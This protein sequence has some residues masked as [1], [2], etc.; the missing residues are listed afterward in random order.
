MQR[1]RVVSAEIDPVKAARARENLVAAGLENIVELRIGDARETLKSLDAPIDFLLIDSWIPLARPIVEMLKS[2]LRPGAL[3]L[4]DNTG[5]FRTEYRDFL[6][7]VRDPSN[8]FLTIHLP[9][10]G[11]LEVAMRR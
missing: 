9:F 5:Q 11:G 10:R 3:V 7:Y 4:C 2:N 1:L 8:G 6:E